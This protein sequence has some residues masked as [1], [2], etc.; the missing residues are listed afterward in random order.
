MRNQDITKKIIEILSK[1]CEEYFRRKTPA[2]TLPS[3]IASEIFLQLPK[4]PSHGDL[5]SNIAMRLA[6]LAKC[7]PLEIA[8]SVASIVQEMF[9]QEKILAHS[10]VD[11]KGGFINITLADEYFHDLLA[12]IYAQKD[13]FGA[14]R[15]GEEKHVNIEFVSAN[16][17]GPL[18][19]AHGRQA[20]IGDALSRILKFN[21][22]KVTNEYY[23]NDIGRQIKLLGQSVKIR[24]RNLFGEDL[25]LPED[26]YVGE[27]VIDIAKKIKEEKG[28]L[29]LKENAET[30]E[31][32]RVRA[33]DAMMALIR[34]D[35]DDF[36]VSFD[37]WTS[38]ES[39]EKKKEVE[40]TLDILEKAGY[41]FESEGAKWF[42]STKFGD[43]KDRVVVKSDGSY[44]YLAPDMAYHLDK[45]RRGYDRLI[46]LLGPDHHGYINRMKAAVQALGRDE[47]SLDILI[48]QLVTLLRGGQ[49]VSMST[50]KAEF[51]SLRELIDEIGRDVTR[52]CFLSRRLDSHL[53]FD[54]EVA[55]KESSDNPVY[56]IQYAHA[57][58]CSIKKFS[59]KRS[60]RLFFVPRRMELLKAKEEL[61]LMRKLSEFPQ[62]IRSGAEALEPNRVLVYLNELARQFH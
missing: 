49:T 59:R 25:P 1:A 20:A 38:Q 39:I 14:S 8:Q 15:I 53:D 5:T 58:I 40:E 11:A 32:F 7:S 60:L 28:D 34:K 22:Y 33:V 55:K 35:L 16:P 36:G 29:F 30:D 47:K 45:Y 24:Y 52:F 21:G 56:Y 27:Y 37:V 50:R 48:V 23:L 62:A 57:R 43:D 3:D 2:Q 42:A 18:T 54:I 41:I 17:T 4:D 26:G 12:E 31:F 51:V 46:D 13:D 9:S 44:T 6:S 10:K 19:I 61:Q